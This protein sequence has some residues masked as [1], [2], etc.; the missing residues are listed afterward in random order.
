[1]QELDIYDYD[2]NYSSYFINFLAGASIISSIISFAISI[3]ISIGIGKL[4]RKLEM[5]DWCVYMQYVAPFLN[6]TRLIPL[7]GGI[8]SF[9]IGILQIVT[10]AYYFGSVGMSKLWAI[11]PI[12]SLIIITIG[13]STSFV[14]AFTTSSET[15]SGGTFM[16]FS[17]LILLIAFGIAYIVANV[18]AGI[19]LEKGIGFLIGLAILPV[20]FQPIL[21]YM[22]DTN[23]K[24][25]HDYINTDTNIE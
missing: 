21:G 11:C 10:L 20:I 2:D 9:I 15:A 12:V 18:K 17:A 16:F 14:G 5:P 4:Y 8:L 6:F 13:L 22:K 1:M 3:L 25:V 7:I 23:K 19:I 24:M